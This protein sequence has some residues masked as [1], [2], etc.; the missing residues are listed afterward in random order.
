MEMKQNVNFW[1]WQTAQLGF[2]SFHQSSVL[3]SLRNSSCFLFSALKLNAIPRI[4]V[5]RQVRGAFCGTQSHKG[6]LSLLQR[7]WAL[8]CG[9]HRRQHGTGN[10]KTSAWVLILTHTQLATLGEKGRCAGDLLNTRFFAYQWWWTFGTC[11]ISTTESSKRLTS[12][13]TAHLNEHLK[14]SKIHWHSYS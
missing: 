1:R 7:T 9:S 4:Y 12:T 3:L 10:T 5:L 14:Q 11:A 13:G 6:P 2:S 8:H